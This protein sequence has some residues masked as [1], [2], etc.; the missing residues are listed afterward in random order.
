MQYGNQIFENIDRVVDLTEDDTIEYSTPVNFIPLSKEKADF[1]LEFVLE[2]GA[3]SL[4][5]SYYKMIASPT[6]VP[7]S[8]V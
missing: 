3:R 7:N 2:N 6:M 8:E 4:R 5:R 1:Y